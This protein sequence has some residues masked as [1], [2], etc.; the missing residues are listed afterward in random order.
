M[1]NILIILLLF[2][3]CINAFGQKSQYIFL[4]QVDIKNLNIKEIDTKDCNNF[5]STNL[6]PN[7]F[8][9]PDDHYFTNFHLNGSLLHEIEAE[10]QRVIYYYYDNAFAKE[11]LHIKRHYKTKRIASTNAILEKSLRDKNGP[12]IRGW[13]VMDKNGI[14]A[15]YNYNDKLMSVKTYVNDNEDYPT[16]S[17]IKYLYDASGHL[18]SAVDNSVPSDIQF[19]IFFYKNNHIVGFYPARQTID[20]PQ[21]INADSIYNDTKIRAIAKML[22]P[23]FKSPNFSN[24]VI[25]K[26]I[27]DSYSPIKADQVIIDG[28]DLKQFLKNKI[29]RSEARYVVM[30]IADNYFLFYKLIN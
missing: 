30:E 21:A 5:F 14:A 18:I 1:R 4:S 11:W 3:V 19:N 6:V 12:F 25:K 13:E 2:I 20:S 23:R 28:L 17:R 22:S 26:M 15:E 27:E 10:D 16:N 7:S 8:P 24:E 29:N 9:K